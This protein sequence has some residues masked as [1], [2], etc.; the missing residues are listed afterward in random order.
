MMEEG[1]FTF[2]GEVHVGRWQSSSWRGKFERVSR[3]WI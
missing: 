2:E 3:F 1:R